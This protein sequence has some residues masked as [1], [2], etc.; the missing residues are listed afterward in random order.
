MKALRPILVLL[1]FFYASAVFAQVQMIEGTSSAVPRELI[2]RTVFL[3][4]GVPSSAIGL[5]PNDQTVLDSVR[6]AYQAQKKIYDAQ[7]AA[8]IA[9]NKYSDDVY[10]GQSNAAV[11]A[12]M[13]KFKGQLSSAGL[14]A[15]EA[16]LDAH[17]GDVLVSPVDYGLGT[18]GAQNREL[19]KKNLNASMGG[20]VRLIDNMTPNYSLVTTRDPEGGQI[21]YDFNN[22]S[23]GSSLDS[24]WHL[25]FGTAM[26][27][28]NSTLYYGGTGYALEYYNDG[29]GALTGGCQ[30][31][32]ITVIDNTT[33]NY[34]G[35]MFTQN[36]TNN[37]YL[38]N[39]NSNT[40]WLQKIT[41][42][43]GTVLGTT[44]YSWQSGDVVSLCALYN[45]SSSIVKMAVTRGQTQTK[46]KATDS[47]PYTSLY[48]GIWGYDSGSGTGWGF[49]DWNGPTKL[50]NTV[51]TTL[52]GNTICSG[53][54][55]SAT[56]TP[57]VQNQDANGHYGGT[58]YGQGVPPAT[59]INL[60]N[61]VVYPEDLFGNPPA[62]DQIDLGGV[63]MCSVIG[64][65]FTVGG[66]GSP[67]STIDE[68]AIT[69]STNTWVPFLA[70]P[71]L[72]QIGFELNPKCSTSSSPP[73]FD[74]NA[75]VNTKAT[76]V[77]PK[78][79]DEWAYYKGKTWCYRSAT[80]PA[81]TT[82]NCGFKTVMGGVT[83]GAWGLTVIGYDP[84]DG[85]AEYAPPNGDSSGYFCT[86]YDAK[87]SGLPWEA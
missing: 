49:G 26:W 5:L 53:S 47:S 48:P 9:A 50:N 68:D 51:Y 58:V 86:N 25:A 59:N 55:P 54:C 72:V 32:Q 41:N 85:Q 64:R 24:N 33:G 81:G 37:G 28:S 43:A 71:K 22:Y 19:A 74:F 13:A 38:A 63:V 78:L 16:W 75:I 67:P 42:G 45:G 79:P 36:R 69:F 6:T 29:S 21:E 62:P 3:E 27:I 7:A 15:F 77:A 76:V 46:I 30:F 61:N 1:L 52:S 8:A 44:A 23:G 70:G 17:R 11:I 20:H 60:Q 35:L 40:L 56:H 34:G 82:W 31:K 14:I 83:P 84:V 12:A 10:W 73:D 57:N 4:H 18:L 65:F 66:A 39:F 80:A 2:L 87:I